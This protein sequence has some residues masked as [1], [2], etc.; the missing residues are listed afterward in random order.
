[1]RTFLQNNLITSLQR[2]SY[3]GTN[4]SWTEINAG[5]RCYLRPMNEQQASVNN[6]QWGKAF[7]ILVQ[8][9]IDIAEGDKVVI[10]GLTYNVRG[11]A[12]HNRGR[13]P[14]KKAVATLPETS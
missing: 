10:D 9:G 5:I 3:S 8:D 7:N 12:R 2:L 11:V 4:G 1:M 14:Y 13:E 6:Y